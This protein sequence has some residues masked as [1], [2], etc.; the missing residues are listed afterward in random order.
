MMPPRAS[1][2]RP[3]AVQGVMAPGRTSVT[4]DSQSSAGESGR[5][6]GE[7]G[8][9][10]EAD[11]RSGAESMRYDS[12]CSAILLLLL[13]PTPMLPPAPLLAAS[14]CQ[15]GSCSCGA[16]PSVAVRQRVRA[17]SCAR[18]RS[19]W[20]DRMSPALATYASSSV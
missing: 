7:R 18:Q 17:C 3:P 16:R 1:V 6:R 5:R 8:S 4:L 11:R 12:G 2:N 15:C 13:M 14:S 19:Q 10:D 20:E 9:G